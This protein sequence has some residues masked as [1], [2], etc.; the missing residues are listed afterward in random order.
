MM[1]SA[2]PPAADLALSRPR[3]S[4]EDQGPAWRADVAVLALLATAT[5]L[6]WGVT[7][8]GLFRSGDDTSY[9]IAVVGGV[10]M[11]MVFLYPLRKQVRALRDLGA[12]RWWLWGHIALGLGGPW[13]IL[14]HS[15][16]RI[17]SLNAGVALWSMV[18]VVLSGVVGR[19]LH[20]R[21]H[22][23][24]HGELTTLAELRLQAGLVEADAVGRLHFAPAVAAL[25]TAFEEAELGAPVDGVDMFRRLL[26]LP[27]R[28]ALLA[29]RCRRLLRDALRDKPDPKRRAE[30]LRRARRL[31]DRYLGA[32]VR[33]SQ[34]TA[35]ERVFALWHV[36]HVPFVVLLV[37]SAVVHVVAVHAY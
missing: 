6:A 11:L 37:I 31:I 30:S 17:G 34:F 8:L 1:V 20:A 5:L 25:L 22:R 19:F 26:W 7:R 10:M 16:F 18:V 9:R 36:A 32:V 3:S 29:R 14:V 24:L 28:Q 13:L 35:Y 27:L 21:V 15:T 4:L 2:P 12:P 23:G 33:V